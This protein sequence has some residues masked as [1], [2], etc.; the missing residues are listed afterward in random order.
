LKGPVSEDSGPEMLAGARDHV[1]GPL[2]ELRK[3]SE[4]PRPE[5]R[6]MG[7]EE[8]AEAKSQ[9]YGTRRMEPEARG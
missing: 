8:G 1:E 7:Q 9:R 4:R 2:S 5:T 6:T 3:G